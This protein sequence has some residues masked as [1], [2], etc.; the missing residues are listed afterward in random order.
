MYVCVWKFCALWLDR[1]F[2]TIFWEI[3]SYHLTF[4][5]TFFVQFKTFLI[6]IVTLPMILRNWYSGTIYLCLGSDDHWLPDVTADG[7]LL[8]QFIPYLIMHGIHENIPCYDFLHS[9]FLGDDCLICPIV[10]II[11]WLIFCYWYAV[12]SSAM[13][14][15]CACILLL[16]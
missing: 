2:P 1:H 15:S 12:T 16:K 6:D 13:C 8:F 11:P 10:G 4:P 5:I 7:N 14:L 9:F 3:Y